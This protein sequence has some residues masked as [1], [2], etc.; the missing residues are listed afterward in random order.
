V[1]LNLA[2][3]K[4]ERDR[5]EAER[6]ARE[7]TRRAAHGEPALKDAE[8]M[9]AAEAPDAVL[10]EAVRITVDWSVMGGT[11]A[12]QATPGKPRMVHAQPQQRLKANAG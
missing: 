5:L 2:K 11:G 6:L 4:T 3:R 1:S 9:A 7:N 12:N 10:A 8:A